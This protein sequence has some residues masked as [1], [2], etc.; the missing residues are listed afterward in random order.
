MN[1]A[2]LVLILMIAWPHAGTAQQAI[3]T[4][5]IPLSETMSQNIG[6]LFAYPGAKCPAGSILFRGPETQMAKADNAVYC[7]VTKRP[8][9]MD[10]KNLADGKC[11]AGLKE[12]EVADKSIKPDA[13]IIWCA[14]DL[15][16]RNPDGTLVKKPDAP[17][18][19]KAAS[20]KEKK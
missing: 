16:A 14:R 13:D 8:I 18:S 17:V 9:I 15:P 10:K 12:Y 11:P 7:V 3:T 1:I 20:D 2:A 6:M 19:D 5:V 4:P